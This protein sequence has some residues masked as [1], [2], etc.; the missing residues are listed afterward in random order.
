[1]KKKSKELEVLGAS[2]LSLTCKSKLG[3]LHW[4]YLWFDLRGKREEKSSEGHLGC[5]TSPKSQG[6]ASEGK[7]GHTKKIEVFLR[8]SSSCRETEF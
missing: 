5:L 6:K 1:M 8:S 2:S 7:G 3:F 4:G